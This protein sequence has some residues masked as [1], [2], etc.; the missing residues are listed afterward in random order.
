MSNSK[1]EIAFHEGVKAFNQGI[2]NN[3]YKKSTTE[4]KWWNK[5]YQCGQSLSTLVA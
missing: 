2:N 5:G 3:P 1:K 4:Y